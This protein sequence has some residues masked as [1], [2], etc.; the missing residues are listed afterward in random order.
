MIQKGMGNTVVGEVYTKMRR[1]LSL[2][3]CAALLPTLLSACQVPA[4]GS[5]STI[6]SAVTECEWS[7]AALANLAFEHS[8]CEDTDD[9]E[10]ISADLDREG[11]TAYIENAYGIQGS[12]KDA[13]LVRATGASA[14]EI[15][16]LCMEDSTTAAQAVTALEAY[17]ANR[18]GDF[19][20]YAPAEADMVANGRIVQDGSFA[21]L[22]ICP[23]ANGAYEVVTQALKGEIQPAP[24]STIPADA[25]TDVK[26][27]RDW[28][29][30]H[31]G[32]DGTELELLD[33]SDLDALEAY[34]EDSYGLKRDQWMEC[35]IARGTGDS[36]FEVAVMTGTNDWALCSEIRKCLDWYLNSRQI[37][38]QDD[39]EQKSMLS[40]AMSFTAVAGSQEYVYT[41][42]LACKD[43]KQTAY[44]FD[45]TAGT[46]GFTYSDRN[47]LFLEE[48]P[49][50]PGRI[51]F[52]QPNKIDVSFYDTAS[53]RAAWETGDASGLS[54][55]DREIYDAAK[56][57]LNEVLK[58]GMSDLEKE[59][60]I[61]NWLV[62]NV[63]YDGTY[64]DVMEETS[65]ESSTPYGGLVNRTAI[66]LGYVTTFQLLM[67]LAEVE[68]IPVAGASYASQ[69]DHGWNMVRIDGNW[70]CTDV[71]WDANRRA[72]GVSKGERDWRFFNIT[73]DD[74]AATDHQ[75]DYA[76]T[77]EATTTGNGRG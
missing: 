60:A 14:F 12:W 27:L 62:C 37:M 33:D 25:I 51:L 45:E 32:M 49:D 18:Q 21:A 69:E 68:C 59:T 64:Q 56:A 42:L 65:G 2:L 43:A 67:D 28:L 40:Q 63:N 31:C 41:V 4:S 20:G 77:P 8:G 35:A 29:V 70:Y 9:L 55:Y 53:V 48:D 54:S 26:E 44:T 75:W 34:I 5:T 73:S 19:V 38:F 71:T 58:E 61:Y 6:S 1:A 11:L 22:L 46:R 76:N 72:S 10:A 24:E 36:A 15:A 13:A 50:H 3:L 30:S 7:A 47:G 57:V 39:A 66:C 16:V 17:I 52:V 74:M 23:E